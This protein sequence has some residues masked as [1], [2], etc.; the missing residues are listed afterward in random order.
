M[1]KNILGGIQITC[2]CKKNVDLLQIMKN[3]VEIL[4]NDTKEIT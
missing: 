3:Y 4:W 1:K 2:N